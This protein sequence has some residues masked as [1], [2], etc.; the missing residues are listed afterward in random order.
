MK[1]RVN[2]NCVGCGMCAGT[3][4]EVFR[5]TDA[6]VAEAMEGEVPAGLEG[7]AAAAAAGCPVNAIEENA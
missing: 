3:C 7:S 5:M 4:P 2:D 6:G 1:Y